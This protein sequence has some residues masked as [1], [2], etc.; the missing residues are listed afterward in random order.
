MEESDQGLPTIEITVVDEK[1]HSKCHACGEEYAQAL[2]AENLS[3]PSPEEY[4]ACSRCLSKVADT[5]KKTVPADEE[6]TIEEKLEK[7]SHEPIPQIDVNASCQH[8]LGY[9]KKRD[10]SSPIPDECLICTKMI[11]CM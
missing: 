6:P 5:E 10:R 1:E 4:Y 3:G 7:V 2:L 8:Q 9:L 11:D